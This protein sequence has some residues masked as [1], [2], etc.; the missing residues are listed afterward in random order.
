MEVK[1]YTLTLTTEQAQKNIDEL[2]ESFELQEELVDGLEKELRKY[3]YMT[4]QYTVRSTSKT[5][6]KDT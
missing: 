4:S 1:D 6:K 3:E 5:G 2:N